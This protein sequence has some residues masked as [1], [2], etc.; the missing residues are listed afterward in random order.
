MGG[1]IGEQF[2]SEGYD[3]DN[4][5]KDAID[6][7]KKKFKS[8]RNA[9]KLCSLSDDY[10]SGITKKYRTLKLQGFNFS[11]NEVKDL[12]A[13]LNKVFEGK[14][15]YG[16]KLEA[17]WIRNN[18]FILDGL[19]FPLAVAEEKKKDLCNRCVSGDTLVRVKNKGWVKIVNVKSTDLIWDGTA[20]INHDGVIDNGKR[21]VTELNGVIAT[22]DHKFLGE[23]GNWHDV[24]Q[25]KRTMGQRRGTIQ[26]KDPRRSK[27]P[28][29]NWADIW[30]LASS[31]IK[32]YF[33][34]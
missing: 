12:Q 8:T 30:G 6:R 19:G 34:K 1:S 29:Y 26:Q 32:S 10:G 28:S 24:A 13:R 16:R 25:F 7:V 15:A 14:K 11:L 18:G 23:D 31:I 17:E 9:V 33:Q 3:P 21:N 4:P 20:W 22:L 27:L 5:T 2:K